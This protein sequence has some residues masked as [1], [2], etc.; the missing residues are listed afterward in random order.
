M[1][2][3][4]HIGSGAQQIDF[5]VSITCVIFVFLYQ[6]SG[7]YGF[8]LGFLIQSFAVTDHRFPLMQSV[9]NEAF[10]IG[11]AEQYHI[12]L[13]YELSALFRFCIVMNQ[14]R[15]VRFLPSHAESLLF[16][17]FCLQKS[18]AS[19]KQFLHGIAE[20]NLVMI[21]IIRHHYKF[22]HRFPPF[23]YNFA[24]DRDFSLHVFLHL[25]NSSVLLQ[26]HSTSECTRLQGIWIY[27]PG[28]RH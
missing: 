11:T 3:R 22:L 12:R 17:R 6:A 21:Q 27:F 18:K 23:F 13:F 20:G 25:C 10:I 15:V 19:P 2:I 8:P 28:L 1:E 16:H 7:G 5:F 26:D 4:R 24:P 14:I 9:L